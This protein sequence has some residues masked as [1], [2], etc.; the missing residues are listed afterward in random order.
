LSPVEIAQLHRETEEN[1]SQ[2]GN[3]LQ[4]MTMKLWFHSA[5]GL[6]LRNVYHGGQCCQCICELLFSL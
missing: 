2:C 5:S 6:S 1:A 3:L 4:E